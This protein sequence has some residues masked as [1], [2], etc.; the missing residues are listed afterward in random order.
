MLPCHSGS[1][2]FRGARLSLVLL[3]VGSSLALA[4]DRKRRRSAPTPTPG[5][6]EGLGLK[7]IP[8]TVGHEAKGLILPNYDI[9]GNLIGRFEAASAARVDENHVRFTNLKMTTFDDRE[10]PDFKVDMSDAVLDLETRVIDS[11]ARTNVKRADFEIAGDS[12]SFNTMTK[13]GTLK[14]NVHMTIFNQKE[15]AGSNAK[16]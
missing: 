14:G 7:N 13:L 16:P 3:L 9:K 10:Q 2:V 12:M 5:A 8:L 4:G 1:R 6:T 11:R 15:I